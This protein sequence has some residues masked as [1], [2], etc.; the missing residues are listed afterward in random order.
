MSVVEADLAARATRRSLADAAGRPAVAACERAVLLDLE[1]LVAV[2]TVSGLSRLHTATTIHARP[3][4]PRL[5]MT[6]EP[7]ADRAAA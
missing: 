2:R 4:T 5:T 6:P 3:F 7:A 1:M